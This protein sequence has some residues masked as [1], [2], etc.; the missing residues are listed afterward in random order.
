MQNWKPETI[1]SFFRELR[2]Q[3]DRLH[4]VGYC[5]AVISLIILLF[6]PLSLSFAWL[7]WS[8]CYVTVTWHGPWS[9]RWSSSD[10]HGTPAAANQRVYARPSCAAN[11]D[12][13]WTICTKPLTIREPSREGRLRFMI[14]TIKCQYSL[15]LI[16]VSQHQD[17]HTWCVTATSMVGRLHKHRYILFDDKIGEQ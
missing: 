16:R 8:M 5:M 15:S 1:C 6:S 4:V 12:P 3:V 11:S 17:A 2:C 10:D 14:I 13:A 7:D 9:I